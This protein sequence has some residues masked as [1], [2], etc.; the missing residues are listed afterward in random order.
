MQDAPHLRAQDIRRACGD[1]LDWQVQAI[2]ASGANAGELAEAIAYAHG[3]DDVMGDQRK[4]LSGRVAL[5]H[6][7]LTRDEPAADGGDPMRP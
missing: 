5:V 1:I 3:E 2:L 4:P 6:E 7:I